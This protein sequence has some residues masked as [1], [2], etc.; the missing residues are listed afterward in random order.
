MNKRIVIKTG[1]VFKVNVNG[2]Y[3]V[4]FQFVIDDTTQLTS[5]VIRVFGKHYEM[6]ESPLMEDVVNDDVVFYAHTMLSAGIRQGLWQK[7]GKSKIK[8]N[9]DTIGFKMLNSPKDFTWYVWKINSPI[10]YYDVLPANC[11]RYD[12]GWVYAPANLVKRIIC[13]H[14]YV[15]KEEEIW[16]KNQGS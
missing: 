1:D 7:V 3:D 8:D 10:E 12:W 4:Y 13:G 16:E 15:I 2:Q 5:S 11:L 9:I 14:H 6:D